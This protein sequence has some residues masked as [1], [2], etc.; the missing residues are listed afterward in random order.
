MQ[1]GFTLVELLAILVVLGIITIIAVPNVIKTNQKSVENDYNEFKKTV[2]NAAEIYVE[3]HPDIK[4][5][6]GTDGFQISIIDL[7]EAG[8][9]NENL[10]NPKNNNGN[11]ENAIVIVK[12]E[13]DTLIYT[14][15][16]SEA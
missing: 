12:R 2:E 14:F 5:K 11:I 16:E 10:I 7:K 8:L 1:K 13:E 9:I 6:I 15:K 4:E 3:T